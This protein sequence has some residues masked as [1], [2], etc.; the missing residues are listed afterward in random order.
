MQKSSSSETKSP[1]KSSKSLWAENHFDILKLRYDD[2]VTLLRKLTDIDLQVFGGYLTVSLAFASW[3]SQ[4][5]PTDTRSTVGL[6]IISLAF[7][8]AA[9]IMLLFNF[10][11]RLE[12]IETVQNI[13]EALGYETVGA[14]IEGKKINAKTKFR[15]WRNLYFFVI[16]VVF[17]GLALLLSAEMV[18]A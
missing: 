3:A 10:K 9:S 1:A 17:A 5:P 4:Y 12:I 2:Q 18:V 15:P 6:L 14:L 11:R 13:N 16:W 8:F 7:A